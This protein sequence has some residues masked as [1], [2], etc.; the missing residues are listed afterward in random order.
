LF[1]PPEMVH[2]VAA[3]VPSATVH[4]FAGTGH[5][6]YWEAPERFN[7]LLTYWLAKNARW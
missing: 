6:P 4:D 2:E 7:A 3:Y 1:F 5:S